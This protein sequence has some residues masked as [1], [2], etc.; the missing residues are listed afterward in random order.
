MGHGWPVI[1]CGI[2]VAATIC[3]GGC[4]NAQRYRGLDLTTTR[5]SSLIAVPAAAQNGRNDCG[6][7]ALASVALYHRAAASRLVEGEVPQSF[8]GERLAAADLVKMA[9]KLELKAFGYQGSVDDLR[10]NVGKG[11]PVL[12]LLSQPPRVEPR[13]FF[14]FAGDF[15][16][17]GFVIP[18]WVVVCGFTADDRVVVH[19][20]R[21]GLITM[22]LRDFTQLWERTS[23]VAV[24]V[25]RE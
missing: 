2:A 8:R 13:T 25:V 1:F 5:P 3:I 22:G 10:E 20:P 24:L 14:D 19:D 16:S 12:V 11:R 17:A 6:Y 23:R 9:A 4:A 7:A 15:A 18:H 21:N